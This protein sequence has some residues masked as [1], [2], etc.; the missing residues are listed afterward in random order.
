MLLLL[1]CVATR[2]QDQVSLYTGWSGDSQNGFYGIQAAIGYAE[3]P[4]VV[5]RVSAWCG[6]DNKAATWAQCGWGKTVGSASLVYFE[7]LPDYE[8][9]RRN[10][11]R[12]TGGAPAA[13]Q[14]YWVSHLVLPDYGLDLMAAYAGDV[15]ISATNWS[16][17]DAE[18]MCQWY[19]GVER[20]DTDDRIPGTYLNLVKFSNRTVAENGTGWTASPNYKSWWSLYG[21]IVE[22]GNGSDFGVY[23]TR[24]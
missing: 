22:I 14:Q 12:R 6:I 18:Q 3:P 21:E 24:N 5:A 10:R 4:Q 11:T 9:D 2:A 13:S 1:P 19:C 20:H 23:D 7:Y 16:D 15:Y 17:F 8:N